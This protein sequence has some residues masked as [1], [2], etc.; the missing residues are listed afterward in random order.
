MKPSRKNVKV[1]AYS[2]SANLSAGF[3]TAAVALDAFYD[4]VEITYNGGNRINSTV[5]GIGDVPVEN[6]TTI[7]VKEV[8]E[9]T[10]TDFGVDIKLIK[11][12]PAGKGLGSSGASAAA[13]AFAANLM[14]NSRLSIYDLVDIA[15]KAEGAFSGTP[16]ADN[17]SASLLGGFSFVYSK[18]P[19]NAFSIYRNMGFYIA[20]PDIEINESK[21]KKARESLGQPVAFEQYVNEKYALIKLI[22]GVLYG[23]YADIAAAINENSYHQKIRAKASLVPF[24]DEIKTELINSGA[25]GVC[26]SGAGPSL[27]I[28]SSN[29]NF[30]NIITKIYD[31]FNIR[32]IVKKA[33][34][35][36][37]VYE[38]I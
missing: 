20:L 27:L 18:N 25:D 2:S 12:I 21:T 9:R 1:R 19:F 5:T 6:T 14:I 28:L 32:V 36:N 31:K 15:A 16:H 37:G 11:G 13:G 7:A 23:D 30:E 10:G 24:F 34:V 38:I 8:F 3:D 35:A 29:E 17:V 33:E 26:L 22:K 4:D